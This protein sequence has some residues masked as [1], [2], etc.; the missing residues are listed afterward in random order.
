MGAPAGPTRRKIWLGRAKR[1]AWLIGPWLLFL[2]LPFAVLWRIAPGFSH[3]TIGNDYT[4]YPIDGQL[5]F[6]WSWSNGMMPVFVPGFDGG[7]TSAAMTLG[8]AWHPITWICAL[9]PQFK[10]GGAEVVVTILRMLE[11]GFT[12]AIVHRASRRS[13][14]GR[15][16]SFLLS[17]V[18]VF[19]AR[20][21]DSFRYGPSL[22]GYCG[23]LL[24]CATFASGYREGWSIGRVSLAAIAVYLT[25]VSGHPQWAL[26]ATTGAGL[27]AVCLPLVR[28]QLASVPAVPANRFGWLKYL[29][30]LGIAS[31]SGIVLA[32]GYLLPFLLEFMPQN[33]DRVNQEYA[34]TLG[35]GD[36]V[37]GV[38]SNF[39]R[40]MEA[41]VHGAFGGGVLMLALVLVVPI[42]VATRRRFAAG[43]LAPAVLLAIAVLF[44]MGDATPVHRLMVEHLP[45]FSSFR[46]PGRATLW[47]P[48]MLLLIG[49]VALADLERPDVA[50]PWMPVPAIA[51]A[52][53]LSFGA[54]VLSYFLLQGQRFGDSTPAALLK[55]PASV[56]RLAFMYLGVG[57]AM[58]AAFVVRSPR[59]RAVAWTLLVASTVAC[60]ATTLSYGTWQ[61]KRK[62]M[63]TLTDID[64]HHRKHFSFWG[65]AGFGL[66]TRLVSKAQAAKITVRRETGSVVDRALFVS[67][68]DDA[69]ST[70]KAGVPTN[71]VIL[72]GP[73]V[74]I[75]NG[76]GSGRSRSVLTFVNWNRWVFAVDAPRGGVFVLGHPALKEWRAFVD[77]QP[78]DVLTA[79]GVFA[80]VL[81]SPG[82]H[83]IEFRYE[84]KATTLGGAM[85]FVGF[86][87]LIGANG[88]A[89]GRRAGTRRRKI[90]WWGVTAVGI[91]LVATTGAIFFKW[92]KP[93]LNLVEAPR[94]ADAPA[95]LES[96][97]G[98]RETAVRRP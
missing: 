25:L 34:F 1:V 82:D 53:A 39:V 97:A 86:I 68:N 61:A 6:I 12:H 46:T 73:E 11:L 95:Q 45:L 57:A 78:A 19:N 41:D 24:A 14:L 71:T 49:W 50:R 9:I 32:A 74:P 91:G 29:G 55:V 84:S 35:Y 31:V 96:V 27:F 67:T 65:D 36:T 28:S 52:G 77:G 70:V 87:A 63:R 18:V 88:F 42:L 59:T 43:V 58:L 26:F 47:I 92:L 5:E 7:N 2:A 30:G 79:N 83:A 17:F 51:V 21:L 16:S 81:V 23:M 15:V 20:M 56:P 90:A 69:V 80:A 48:P 72:T 37:R 64:K 85:C 44:A 93:T 33:G 8:Q 3:L 62:T 22:E 13:G 4:L 54:L 66:G 98:E 60:A 76:E 40:P 89:R 75:P 38:L 94:T 10:T